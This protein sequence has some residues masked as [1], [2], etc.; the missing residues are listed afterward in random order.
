MDELYR[1]PIRHMKG[2]L[3]PGTEFGMCLRELATDKR[4][5]TFLEIGN[6]NGQGS[7][8]SIMQGLMSRSDATTF[9]S[10]EANKD[11]YDVSVDFWKDIDTLNASL[12][13]R[14]GKL[15]DDIYDFEYVRSHKRFIPDM[16]RWYDL[17][18]DQVK[19]APVIDVG[20]ECIDFVLFDGGEF[21]TV[22]DWTFVMENF[23]PR[24]VALDDINS[25]KTC[26]IYEELCASSEWKLVFTGGH[27]DKVDK[28]TWAVFERV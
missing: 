13:L 1:Y 17:E 24:I 10:L 21:C 6:W 16:E 23:S 7:T 27:H 4:S 2:Q 11:R 20:V 8:L 26:D 3:H 18:V 9:V 14:Y 15:S 28:Y 12:D 5:K 22:G 19:Q 25:F